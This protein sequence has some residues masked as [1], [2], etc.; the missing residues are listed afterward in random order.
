MTDWPR[1]SRRVHWVSSV[2]GDPALLAA[3][4]ERMSRFYG[5]SDGRER[6]PYQRML[7]AQDGDPPD[8]QS[9]RHLMPRY[10][11]DLAPA[12]VLEVGCGNGRLYRQL[13]SYGFRG[14]YLGVEVAPA[15]VAGNRAAHPEAA[16]ETATAYRLPFAGG[17]FDLCFSLY[18]LEHLVYPERALREML[19]VL[20]PGGRLVLVFP[21]LAAGGILASQQ[22]GL[23]PGGTAAGKL[24]AGRLLDACVSLYDSRFRMRRLLARAADRWGPFPVNARPL[25]LS[26]PELMEPDVDAVYIASKDEIDRWAGREGLAVEYPAG[27]EGEMSFQAFMVLTKPSP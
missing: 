16:W 9:V 18:V 14:D 1:C 13:R 10:V 4:D 27:R 5:R 19:R 2:T 22:I 8:R 3:L 20:R 7:D 17:R 11:C 6:D 26:C 15:V 24:R 12:S 25:C 21:D 23:S